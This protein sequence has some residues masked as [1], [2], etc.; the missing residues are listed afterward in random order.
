L[1]FLILSDL[2][3]QA[4][5]ATATLQLAPQTVQLGVGR[6]ETIDLALAGVSGLY[7]VE[8]HLRFDPA[9]LEIL[10]SDLNRDGV[11]IESGT[12]PVPDFVAL[13]QV[14][15]VAGTV[16][17]AVTQLSPREPS[18]GSGTVAEITLKGKQPATSQIE[19]ESFILTDTAAGTIDAVSQHGQVEIRRNVPWL[20]FAAGG[21]ALLLI[22]GGIGYAIAL[23][24]K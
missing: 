24:R 6:T 18:E 3:V 21:G 14:D 7:G 5:Q 19:I 2:G 15:N 10:D 23:A 16:D 11:Q 8:V 1:S 9:V 22:A 12:F 13:N 4:G 17:Y 20:L